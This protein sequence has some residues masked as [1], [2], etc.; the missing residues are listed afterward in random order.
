MLGV[1]SIF[2]LWGAVGGQIMSLEASCARRSGPVPL[3]AFLGWGAWLALFL[4]E[5]LG[6]TLRFDGGSLV[7]SDSGWARLMLHARWLPQ[8]AFAVAAA[9]FLFGR[10]RLGVA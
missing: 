10:E 9:L 4:V 3:L 6:L 1:P 2:L 7:G 5:V 8:L